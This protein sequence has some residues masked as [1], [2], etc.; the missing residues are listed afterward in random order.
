MYEVKIGKLMVQE[1]INAR[2]AEGDPY[3]YVDINSYSNADLSVIGEKLIKKTDLFIAFMD[4]LNMSDILEGGKDYSALEYKSLE[5]VFGI[6]DDFTTL[7]NNSKYYFDEN[8]MQYIE[9]SNSNN[10]SDEE[11]GKLAFNYIYNDTDEYKTISE[12]D[13]LKIKKDMKKIWHNIEDNKKDLVK[14]YLLN[15]KKDECEISSKV[16]DEIQ[17]SVDKIV[18]NNLKYFYLYD[19]KW[20]KLSELG[21]MIWNKAMKHDPIFANISEKLES[22]ESFDFYMECIA[23]NIKDDYSTKITK[24]NI[25]DILRNYNEIN[26]NNDNCNKEIYGAMIMATGEMCV[27]HLSHIAKWD[28]VESMWTLIDS[29]EEYYLELTQ[30]ALEGDIGYEFYFG[31]EGEHDV[32]D[33]YFKNIRDFQEYKPTIIM[34]FDMIDDYSNR[35]TGK[36]MDMI[37]MH[38]EGY[39]LGLE[40]ACDGVATS[41]VNTEIMNNVLKLL[42]IKGYDYRM[43]DNSREEENSSQDIDIN[44]SSN[45]E[46]ANVWKEEDTEFFNISCTIPY[47]NLNGEYKF[48]DEL[49]FKY[50]KANERAIMLNDDIKRF[51]GIN[52][53]DL[54]KKISSIYKNYTKVFGIKAVELN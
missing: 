30:K 9:K 52:L 20:E 40:I 16:W 24:S 42:S 47:I 19:G 3:E 2:N 35:S 32:L 8:K 54:T 29:A 22:D 14:S 5:E 34:W 1:V 13:I 31:E 37:S 11:L 51:I 38:K 48:T 4:A 26:C 7:S 12:E 39:S 46:I 41:I 33:I 36:I 49:K 28:E 27:N 21:K 43:V 10:I 17:E 23:N 44:F 45:L 25:H 53:S 6:V 15:P 50:D 18:V